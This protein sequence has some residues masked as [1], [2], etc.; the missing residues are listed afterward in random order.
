MSRTFYTYAIYFAALSG[1]LIL[2]Q[3]IV[4]FAIGPR[5]FELATTPASVFLSL[6]VAAVNWLLMIAYFRFRNYQFPLWA[7]VGVL[8]TNTLQTFSLLKILTTR[9][10][11]P[12]FA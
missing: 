9:E 10:L 5:I 7:V 1:I 11:T 12:F 3:S 6:G 2:V 4:Y 8:T